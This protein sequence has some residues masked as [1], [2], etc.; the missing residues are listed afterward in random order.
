VADV[1]GKHVV[2]GG[3]GYW[4]PALTP[5]LRAGESVHLVLTPGTDVEHRLWTEWAEAHRATLETLDGALLEKIRAVATGPVAARVTLLDAR[6]A[7]VALAVAYARTPRSVSLLLPGL[8]GG[9]PNGHARVEPL[10]PFVAAYAAASL[11]WSRFG[12]AGKGRA[13]GFPL[14]PAVV[15]ANDYVVVYAEAVASRRRV[16]VVVPHRDRPAYL[17]RTLAALALQSEGFDKHPPM[18]V[19]VADD[20]STERA[21]AVI[22]R[23]EA[24]AAARGDRFQVVRVDVPQAKGGREAFTPARTRNAGLTWVLDHADDDLSPV[25][26]LD[27]DM[28]PTKGFVSRH[29]ALL[30]ALHGQ[31]V[32]VG[33]RGDLPDDVLTLTAE[34]LTARVLE[35]LPERDLFGRNG[36]PA[37]RAMLAGTDELR[38]SNQP[39]MTGASGNMSATVGLIR[40]AG[41]MDEYFS[42]WGYEDNEW[43]YRL[44][45]A[46]GAIVPDREAL[47]LHQPHPPA[48]DRRADMARNREAFLA[49]CPAARPLGYDERLARSIDRSVTGECLRLSFGPEAEDDPGSLNAVLSQ[50]GAGAIPRATLRSPF[51]L[52]RL[53]QYAP[54]A[55]ALETGLRY[56]RASPQHVVVRFAAAPGA[57]LLRTRELLKRGAP[58]ATLVGAADA[59]REIETEAARVLV[60]PPGQPGFG[61]APALGPG[62]HIAIAPDPW[63]T[64]GPLSGVRVLG[65]KGR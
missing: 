53:G 13:P 37:L 14:V 4:A 61:A 2:V 36:A 46:G 19:V 43:T 21:A 32:V 5:L 47:A 51:T 39:F 40:R 3:E 55:W 6:P 23:H 59:I 22:A 35:R 42:G 10:P 26:L 8:A 33:Y 58:A 52:V 60:V 12:F 29:A 28:L 9:E 11:A 7:S 30:R 57:V 44:W 34:T 16:F 17:D 24:Q 41:L 49:R 31:G 45:Q 63:A 1:G 15:G 62:D 20:G 48:T 18:T 25:I 54:P 64:C 56:L 38:R 27:C 50:G 65:Q